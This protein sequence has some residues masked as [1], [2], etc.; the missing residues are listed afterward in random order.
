MGRL[1]LIVFCRSGARLCSQQA[2]RTHQWWDGLVLCN[3]SPHT[4][5]RCARRWRTVFSSLVNFTSQAI[6]SDVCKKCSLTSRERPFELISTVVSEIVKSFLLK[7]TLYVEQKSR[8]T[9]Q[10]ANLGYEIPALLHSLLKPTRTLIAKA[11]GREIR[12]SRGLQLK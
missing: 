5:V 12:V 2:A 10:A 6:S 8:L 9:A 3:R 7:K 11:I 4:Q 1:Q